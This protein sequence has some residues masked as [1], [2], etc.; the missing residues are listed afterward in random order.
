MS[1][2]NCFTPTH[3]YAAGRLNCALGCVHETCVREDQ[4]DQKLNHFHMGDFN[5]GTLPP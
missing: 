4:S 3:P 2:K 5:L 1:V